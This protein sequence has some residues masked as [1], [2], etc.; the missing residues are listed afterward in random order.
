MTAGRQASLEAMTVLAA[1]HVEVR[2]LLSGASA[3]L[4]G[5]DGDAARRTLLAGRELLAVGLDEHIRVED[6]ELFPVIAG[7]LGQGLVG[8][9]AEEHVRIL[10]ARDEVLASLAGPSFATGAFGALCELLESHTVREDQMLFPAA[11]EALGG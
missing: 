7:E 3:A 4:E 1:E 10:E 5:G 8:I 2:A 6:E 11:R 9:F